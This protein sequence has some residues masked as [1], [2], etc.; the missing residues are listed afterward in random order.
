MTAP[1]QYT[2]F[3]KKPTRT[4]YDFH[5][6][7]FSQ[8]SCEAV[9]QYP[10]AAESAEKVCKVLEAEIDEIGDSRR[11]FVGGFSMGGF[12]VALAW[13]KFNKPL[14]GLIIYSSMSGNNLSINSEQEASPVLLSHG[15]EDNFSPYE[16]IRKQ[17]IGLENG[18]R[19]ICQVLR[20]GLGH[21][22]DRRIQ[23]ETR[24]F[25]EGALHSPNL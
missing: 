24:S 1:K 17:N 9:E 12:I 15:L 23:V 13:K 10:Q 20:E 18:K 16:E 6:I 25:I 11:C 4:W 19:R 5:F 8:K 22:V 7:D 14:G 2:T 21:G 3:Y